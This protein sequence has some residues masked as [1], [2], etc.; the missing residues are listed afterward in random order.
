MKESS[1]TAYRY[2]GNGGH[3]ERTKQKFEQSVQLFNH[4]LEF[5][6]SRLRREIILIDKK[7]GSY[8]A[9]ENDVTLLPISID[10]KASWVGDW[11]FKN[12]INAIKQLLNEDTNFAKKFDFPSE[13]DQEDNN[14]N[15]DSGSGSDSNRDQDADVAISS[16]DT[17]NQISENNGESKFVPNLNLDANLQSVKDESQRSD[18]TPKE[19]DAIRQSA[20][21]SASSDFKKPES[22]Q[23]EQEDNSSIARQQDQHESNQQSRSQPQSQLQSQPQV[24]IETQAQLQKPG[25]TDTT[26]IPSQKQPESQSQSQPQSQPQ[27]QLQSQSQAQQLPQQTQQ[28]IQPQ[29]QA[30]KQDDTIMIDL[31]SD[32]DNSNNNFDDIIQID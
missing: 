7:T 9:A 19:S 26:Q 32:H 31:D 12:Q 1:S 16:N 4:D 13:A 8:T 23:P 2:G 3:N 17:D 11:K 15:G 28:E 18:T 30:V 24:Q 21:N 14:D 10:K 29:P 20:E 27:S 25:S 6:S 5:M 22:E